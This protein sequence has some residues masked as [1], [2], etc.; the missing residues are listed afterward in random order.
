[1]GN[2][3]FSSASLSPYHFFAVRFRGALAQPRQAHGRSARFRRGV[4]PDHIRHSG[5][6]RG[7]TRHDEAAPLR[8]GVLPLH[9]QLPVLREGPGPQETAGSYRDG[10]VT[11]CIALIR[12]NMKTIRRCQ[13][14]VGRRA[15]M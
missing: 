11:H 1:M 2:S 9:T 13:K 4:Y 3:S 15:K 10:S 6:S 14:K 12:T 5:R 8:P 7:R